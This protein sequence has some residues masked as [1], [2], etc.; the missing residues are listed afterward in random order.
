[1]GDCQRA[2]SFPL[3]F[4]V[5]NFSSRGQNP[6]DLVVNF[7]DAGRVSI[8]CRHMGHIFF[9]T[10]MWREECRHSAQKRC[11]M[12]SRSVSQSFIYATAVLHGRN[13]DECK[14]WE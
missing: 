13:G 8:F 4:A 6:F 1:M 7:P 10:S 2:G 5:I 12:G 14:G 9:V 11:P 3:L